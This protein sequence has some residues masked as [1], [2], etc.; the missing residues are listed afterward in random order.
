MVGS[1]ICMWFAFPFAE[2]K[3]AYNRDNANAG[4]H[5]YGGAIGHAISIKDLV[6]DTVHQFAPVYREYVLYSD[7]E[8]NLEGDGD[9]KQQNKKPKKIKTKTFVMLGREHTQLHSN[10]SN[11][12]L[13]NMDVGNLN[14]SQEL[15]VIQ[16]HVQGELQNQENQQQSELN[17]GQQIQQG[18]QNRNVKT[19]KQQFDFL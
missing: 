9:D 5:S 14:Q 18:V 16:E 2:Y 13:I 6:S 7:G 12:L 11:N 19:N 1:A 4:I 8:H 17:G 3:M 10:D 15:S